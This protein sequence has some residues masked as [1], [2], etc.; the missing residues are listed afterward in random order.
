MKNGLWHI[1]GRMTTVADTINWTSKTMTVSGLKADAQL[2][3]TLRDPAIDFSVLSK[4]ITLNDNQFIDM[5]A[6]GN[7]YRKNLRIDS[8][9]TDF[10]MKVICIL[11][12]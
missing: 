4:S 3:G 11:M 10:K 2:K 6:H 9:S 7:V 8:L 12:V 5:R 1:D